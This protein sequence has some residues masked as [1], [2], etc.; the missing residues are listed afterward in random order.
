MVSAT[1]NFGFFRR[2]I[3]A[4]T[5]AKFHKVAYCRIC[6]GINNA[7]VALPDAEYFSI[8][9][10]ESNVYLYQAHEEKCK[11]TRNFRQPISF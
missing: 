5:A 11:Q 8:E 10:V 7:A 3:L 6:L 4:S 9:R 2:L 1:H